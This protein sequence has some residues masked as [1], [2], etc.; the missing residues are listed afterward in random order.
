MP[1]QHIKPH[2][3]LYMH[4][5]NNDEAANLFIHQLHRLAPELILYVMHGSRLHQ[6]ALDK[7]HSVICEFYA[8]REYD[9]SGSIVFFTRKTEMLDPNQVAKRVLK[10]CRKNK[11]TTID[12][13]EIS[14]QF[15]SICIHSD[16]PGALALVQVVRQTLEQAGISIQAPNRVNR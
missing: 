15:D 10:A 16:A 1:L 3:A 2:G 6:L 11:V 8:D 9:Q 13:Q 14:V 4:L 12:N 5:A 7:G